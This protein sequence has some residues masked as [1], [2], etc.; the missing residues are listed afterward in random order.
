MSKAQLIMAPISITG[1][2]GVVRD[3]GAERGV[4]NEDQKMKRRG[5]CNKGGNEE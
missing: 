2:E 3:K 1:Q 4:G 5:G